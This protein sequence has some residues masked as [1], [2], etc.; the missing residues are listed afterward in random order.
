MRAT[1]QM[2]D[3]YELVAKQLRDEPVWQEA[4]PERWVDL[5]HHLNEQERRRVEGAEIDQVSPP[6]NLD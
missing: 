6:S 1:R 3:R 5:L 2:G 4:L